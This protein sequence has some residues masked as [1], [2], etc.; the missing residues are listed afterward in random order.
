MLPL[1]K[2][3]PLQLKK[4]KDEDITFES[5]LEGVSTV[6]KSLQTDSPDNKETLV[7]PILPEPETLLVQFSR[8]LIFTTS[9]VCDERLTIRY[10]LSMP[11]DESESENV[12]CDLAEIARQYLPPDFNIAKEI[13]KLCRICPSDG[14]SEKENNDDNDQKAKTKKPFSI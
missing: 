8:R 3:H 11:N 13:E 4:L 7:E 5:M 1:L 10:C 9:E 14:S 6:I 2:R 12:P